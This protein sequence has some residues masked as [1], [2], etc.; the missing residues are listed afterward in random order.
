MANVWVN[1]FY[2]GDNA[3]LYVDHDGE[4]VPR[5]AMAETFPSDMRAARTASSHGIWSLTRPVK[6]EV[7]PSDDLE[8]DYR[9]TVLFGPYHKY[10]NYEVVEGDI[11]KFIGVKKD[12]IVVVEPGH[13]SGSSVVIHLANLVPKFSWTQVGDNPPE[14]EAEHRLTALELAS[15]FQDLESVVESIP[16][17]AL[18]S[19]VCR[20]G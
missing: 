11:H 12:D 19:E 7:N 20:R 18:I 3:G 8:A 6:V 10:L 4:P 9:L 17:R 14:Y 15:V 16:A 13:Q 5:A 2:K 1:Q